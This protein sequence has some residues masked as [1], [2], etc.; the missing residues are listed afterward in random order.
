MAGIAPDSSISDP[1]RRGIRSS[2]LVDRTFKYWSI[3]PIIVLLT[4]LAVLP[5][6]H[7]LR[8]SFSEVETSGSETIWTY[9]GLK[10]LRTFL[11]DP[12]VPV[13]FWNT[14]VFV[15][16][17]VIV[18]AFIGFFLAITVSRTQRLV[19]FYRTVF[20]F[21]L[22]I[23][24]V[25]ISTMWRL[26][27][28][29]N[30]GFINQLL[31]LIDVAGPTWTAD[32]ALALMCVMVV[33]IWHWTSFVFLIILAGLESL[34]HE[35]NEAAR[36]DGASERQVYR[37]IILP[38]LRPTLITAV[39]LRTL[40]AFKVFDEVFVLT[41][42][43]PGTATELISV[44]AYDVFFTQFRLGYGAFLSLVTAVLM[45]LFVLVYR[46]VNQTR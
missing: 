36:I 24:P 33:D 30:Y 13:A 1:S 21:P 45:L 4:L 11:S 26:M 16:V 14:L 38:L 29:Y 44:Y 39:M 9:V 10:H 43:G 34:P 8:M 15:V 46:R 20:L 19:G 7:L 23:P 22:L 37:Y 17:V 3:V 25:A 28:D 5:T 6:I 41:G 32:P 12:V 31:G 35:L 40:F 27:Y 42:G 18:E 2:Q